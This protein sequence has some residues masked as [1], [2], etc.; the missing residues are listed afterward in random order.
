MLRWASQHA[1]RS[2]A[3]CGALL[4][5]PSVAATDALASRAPEDTLPPVGQSLFDRLMAD[6]APGAPDVPFP[7]AA[8]L[9]RL[10]T[11][12][13]SEEASGGLSVVLIPLGRSLQRHAAGDVD[14]F[15]YPRVVVAATGEPPPHA[16]PGHA[17]LRDRLYIA[18]HEKAAALEV[19]SYNEDAARFEFQLVR[20]YREGGRP[21]TGYANRT[22]CLA[23]HHDGAPIF[24]RQSW[25]ETS[26]N[27]VIAAR[28]AA[29]GR[30]FYGVRWRHGVD[31]PD[32]IDAATKRAGLLPIAQQIWRD[33]CETDSRA[34]TIACRAEA[35]RQALHYRLTGD[36]AFSAATEHTLLAPLRANWR[37]RWP[38]GLP[39]P[40]PQLPNRQPFAGLLA[41]EKTPDDAALRL[42]ADI[43]AAFDPLALRA[44]LEIWHGDDASD[45]RRFIQAL[46]MSFSATDIA[47]IDRRLASMRAAPRT[48]L[49]MEC[50][51]REHPDGRRIDYDCS[52]PD[53]SRLLARVDLRGERPTGGTIDR[54]QLHGTHNVGAIA[55]ADARP[56]AADTHAAAFALARDGRSVRTRQGSV[57][58]QVVLRPATSTAPAQASLDLVADLA[59]LNTAI[60]RLS[61]ATLA[62]TIDALADLP[63]RRTAVLGPLF[64]QLGI[65]ATAP[66]TTPVCP[67]RVQQTPPT[68]APRYGPRT[69]RPSPASAAS[70]TA[71][72]ARFRPVFCTVTTNRSGIIWRSA[73]NACTTACR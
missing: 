54:L 62:G 28:L 1:W 20:D 19:I 14:A 7:F 4:T 60:D 22:L 6:E 47:L 55:L 51:T 66:P 58:R 69:C 21:R 43:S 25:D 15:R 42:Y 64:H 11:R 41:G 2:L 67:H 53:G 49:T 24:S 71:P 70:A 37:R 38:D 39:I 40:D 29:T 52:H 65:A 16:A 30:S 36:T 56:T 12:L 61:A 9:Q 68:R 57:I 63:L 23:C 8:L 31:V 5:A 27:P 72:Q 32:A 33:G 48:R 44:P 13:D 50:S 46:S 45:V 10:A 3:L 17:Y 35:L 34:A 26:A 59:P 73:R 18:Y